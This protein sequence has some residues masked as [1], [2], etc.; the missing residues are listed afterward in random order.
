M[1]QD[2]VGNR[3]EFYDE[4]VRLFNAVP[5]GGDITAGK[6]QRSQIAYGQGSPARHF[7]RDY[8]DKMTGDFSILFESPDSDDAKLIGF[9]PGP[10]LH[11]WPVTM[12][13]NLHLKLKAIGDFDGVRLALLD[14]Y[15][16]RS[17][18]DI[19]KFKAV[20]NW[21][22]INAALGDFQPE[23]GFSF[24]KGII[25][26]ELH[27]PL[28]LGTKV[29]F[30]DIYFTGT[31]S[32]QLIGVTEKPLGQRI[33]ETRTTRPQRNISAF[34][35]IVS[36]GET[37][38]PPT[39]FELSLAW[40][41]LGE[42]LD[43]ANAKLMEILLDEYETERLFGTGIAQGNGSYWLPVDYGTNGK[44]AAGR[45]Y[46]ETESLFL[47]RLW[48]GM[49]VDNDIALARKSTWWLMGSENHDLS[50]KINSLMSSQIFMKH[51]D[52]ADK[53]YPNHG[54]GGSYGYGKDSGVLAGMAQWADGNDYHPRDHHKAWVTFFREFLCQRAKKGLWVEVRSPIYMRAQ[55][56]QMNELYTYC[57]DK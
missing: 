45:L 42:D 17:F 30:D 11:S 39:T 50:Y 37:I 55:I 40:I 24:A 47:Q 32:N 12:K 1:G 10:W 38:N 49:K 13:Y 35:G 21:L 4:A 57:D 34:R 9:T 54:Y 29:W 31:D 28:S 20:G 25:G 41:E 26:C 33:E 8:T 15:K 51:P 14:T 18:F 19:E 23:P 22:Q 6:N 56:A 46:P 7:R 27:M 2:L 5:K 3:F 43:R 52:Y 36:S 53:V 44:I 16:K 48:E